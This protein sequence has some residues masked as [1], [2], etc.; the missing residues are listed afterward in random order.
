MDNNMSYMVTV[1][2][3]SE[4]RD[5]IRYYDTLEG[6]Q[7]YYDWWLEK[8]RKEEVSYEM[9]IGKLLGYKTVQKNGSW[10]EEY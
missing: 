2:D 3:G 4:D 1:W 5:Y 9:S 10:E 6:A 8:F 7:E